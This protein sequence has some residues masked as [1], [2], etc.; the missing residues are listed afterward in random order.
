MSDLY[1]ELLRK[2]HE[3]DD[4]AGQVQLQQLHSI[5]G[6][7][8][9]VADKYVVALNGKEKC[10][11]QIKEM[12]NLLK[13][14]T[15]ELRRVTTQYD[16]VKSELHRSSAMATQRDASYAIEKQ[17]LLDH[18]TAREFEWE[19]ER[20]DLLR[21]VHKASFRPTTS[22]TTQTTE[23][24]K[25]NRG[26]NT[27]TISFS[28]G[29]NTSNPLCVNAATTTIEGDIETVAD[30]SVMSGSQSPIS[31]SPTP[32][33]PPVSYSPEQWHS[34]G[35]VSEHIRSNSPSYHSPYPNRDFS[36]DYRHRSYSR[37]VSLSA[38][39]NQNQAAI[40]NK[41]INYNNNHQQQQ[42]HH[43]S[44]NNNNSP[45]RYGYDSRPRQEEH[46]YQNR[47]QSPT[48]EISVQT[49]LKS[50]HSRSSSPTVVW[51]TDSL[52]NM[53]LGDVPRE[54]NPIPVRSL[55][56]S[57]C[58]NSN[59]PPDLP[60]S[61]TVTPSYD[62]VTPSVIQKVINTGSRQP[63]VG[64]RQPSLGSRQPSVGTPQTEPSRRPSISKTVSEKRSRAI[65]GT[66]QSSGMRT[67]TQTP[68]LTAENVSFASS[69]A[70]SDFTEG[71]EMT[72]AEHPAVRVAW[73]IGATCRLHSDGSEGRII[74]R[75]GDGFMVLIG[76]NKIF[77]SASNIK[78]DD[79]YSKLDELSTAGS[80]RSSERLQSPTS[81]LPP[82]SPFGGK[83]KSALRDKYP[84][85]LHPGHHQCQTRARS[86]TPKKK[87]TPRISGC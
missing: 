74:G 23:L 14:Y 56:S 75:A 44:S 47:Q 12:Q 1:D 50:S 40:Q 58:V 70:K 87:S 18:I 10:D 63:S 76:N 2:S 37:S 77:Q 32:V 59:S 82:A 38:P 46:F 43:K 66:R 21:Q 17:Q 80:P 39:V 22:R 33:P 29:T 11:Y 28:I 6:L 15:V 85:G 16:Y 61:R 51:T 79:V 84:V 42:Q 25:Y 13:D 54:T 8:E 81:T 73:P 71:D 31:L 69:T 36:P 86:Y 27:G 35:S 83:S 68:Q 19:T 53:A 60:S 34:C 30:I 48:R 52:I 62:S 26:T 41:E 57:S 4:G 24:R 45:I 7:A 9:A 3:Q 55:S 5:E 20:A 67:P 65:G 78:I 49:E 64:S 72:V